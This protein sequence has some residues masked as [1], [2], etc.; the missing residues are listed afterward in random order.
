MEYRITRLN[1]AALINFF[2]SSDSAI[3]GGWHLFENHIFK[4]TDNNNYDK[5]TICTEILCKNR[6]K[7]NTPMYRFLREVIL[8][9]SQHEGI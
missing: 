1:A 2:S 9:F 5:S 7:F 8:C 6:K 3:I 4:I